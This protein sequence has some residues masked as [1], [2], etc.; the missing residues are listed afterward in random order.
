MTCENSRNATFSPGS[1]CGPTP[2]VAPDGQT[3]DRSGL[4]R[5]RVNLSAQQ[6]LA[7]GLTISAI[8]GRILP[9]SSGSASLQKSL[10]NR[11]QARTRG[12]GSTLYKLTW[13]PWVTPS[14][15][16]RFRLR[17]SVLRT[18]GIACSGW[19][20]PNATDHIERKGLRPSRA[21]TGR[22]GGYLSEEVVIHLAAWATPAAR[23]H[24]SASGSPGFLNKRLAQSRGKPLSE[25]TFAALS[26]WPTPTPA[27]RDHKSA[28]DFTTKNITLNH[29]AALL[30]EN[31][32][33]ARLTASGQML[34][35]SS[36]GMG[37]GGQLNPAHSRWLMGLPPE[38]DDCAPTET[39][40]MLTRRRS[41]SAP[42]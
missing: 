22:T 37:S 19:A 41:L 5:V 20:T 32:Q 16:S 24:K 12:L 42:T 27:A 13:K 18:S 7:Q 3:I 26:G 38:W 30:A 8:C 15:P 14:G 25:Q 9:G 33:P 2:Y 10:E 34:I 6:A 1:A 35:G 11:L 4:A 23:D 31:P 40:S 28:S 17:A 29:A 39:L 36:A 21:A